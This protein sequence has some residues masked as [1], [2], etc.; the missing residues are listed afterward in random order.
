MKLKTE[1]R[2]HCTYVLF[3]VPDAFGSFL[4]VF[5]WMTL[6]VSTDRSFFGTSFVVAVV[7]LDRIH[8]LRLNSIDATCQSIE[9]RVLDVLIRYLKTT[10]LNQIYR[11]YLSCKQ[12]HRF[13]TGSA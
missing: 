12:W 2:A 13:R 3:R 6:L 4:E 7:T 5:D 9:G 8:T 1:M 10:V 11:T